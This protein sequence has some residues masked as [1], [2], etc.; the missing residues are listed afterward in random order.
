MTRQISA[1]WMAV[2]VALV[3]GSTVAVEGADDSLSDTG[4]GRD[5]GRRGETLGIG[6]TW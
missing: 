4:D 5:S 1:M 2:V 6:T 3:G